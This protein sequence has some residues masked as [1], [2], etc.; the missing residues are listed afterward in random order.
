MAAVRKYLK[1]WL[2]GHWSTLRVTGPSLKNHSRPQQAAPGT[3]DRQP[4]RREK[5]HGAQRKRVLLED[6]DTVRDGDSRDALPPQ[7]LLKDVQRAAAIRNK[8]ERLW[9]IVKEIWKNL[10]NVRVFC[11]LNDKRFVVA[12]KAAGA[13]GTGYGIGHGILVGRWAIFETHPKY[14]QTWRHRSQ[15]TVT[16][17]STAT[18]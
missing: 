14:H 17:E 5:L 18:P 13:C 11:R 8:R 6:A 16:S 4:P 10:Y 12:L 1:K 3:G 2:S 7:G 9:V 15:I